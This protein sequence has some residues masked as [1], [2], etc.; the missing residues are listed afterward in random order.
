MTDAISVVVPGWRA[1]DANDE[2]ISGAKL[3]FYNA[4]TTTEKFVYS[5][6]DLTVSLGAVVTCDSEGYPTSDGNTRVIIYTGTAAYKVVCTTSDNTT[7]WSHDNVRGASVTPATDAAA[8]PETPVVSKTA[9]YVILTTDQGKLIKGVCTSGN[10][11]FTLPSAVEAGDGFRVGIQHAGTANICSISASQVI[12]RPGSGTSTSLV[13]RAYGQ[14]AWF[15]SDGATWTMSESVD[16]YVVGNNAVISVKDRTGTPPVSPTGGDFY[17][18]N[19]T[20]TGAWA[21][22]SL[23]ANTIVQADGSGSWIAMTPQLGWLAYIEDEQILSQYR[24]SGWVDLSNVTAPTS[25]NLEMAEFSYNV[26]ATISAATWTNIPHATTHF[27]GIT[28]ASLSAGTITLPTGKYL[29]MATIN[30]TIPQSI[31]ASI[32]TRLYSSSSSTSKIKSINSRA[33]TV[34]SNNQTAPSILIGYLSVTDAT[35]NFVHQWLSSS[36]SAVLGTTDG[37]GE[38]KYASITIFDLSSMQGPAGSAGSAGTDGVDA[39]HAYQWNTATSGDPGSGKIRGNNATIASITEIGISETNSDAGTVAVGTWDDSTSS[40]KGNIKV[41]KEGAGGSANYHEFA[42]TGA[43]TD[44]GSYWTFPVSYVGTS[45]T[46]GNGA[47]VAVLHVPKGDKGDTGSTGSAGSYA[48]EYTFDTGTTDA[49]PGAGKIRANNAMLSVATQLF[50]SETDRLSVSQAAAIQQF[51]DSTTTLRGYITL[52][53]VATP[54]NRVRFSISGSITDGGTYDKITV[55]YVSGVTTLTAVNVALIFERT[56]DKGP[57][58]AADITDSTIAGRALLT[59]A[60]ATAQRTALSLGSL[61]LLGSDAV[62]PGTGQMTV[63][64]GTTAQRSGSPGNGMFRYNSTLGVHEYYQKSAWQQLALAFIDI[65]AAY[66]IDA[67][68]GTNVASALQSAITAADTGGRGIYLAEGIYDLGSST[69]SI[70]AGMTVVCHPKAVLRRSAEPGT[71]ARMVTVASNVHWTGG[72]LKHSTGGSAVVALESAAMIVDQASSTVIQD[73]II[74]GR[75]Y[76]GLIFDRCT[77]SRCDGVQVWGSKNRAI[78]VYQ[79]CDDIRISNCYVNGY[80]FG[81]TTRYTDYCININ[82]ANTGGSNTITDLVIMNCTMEHPTNDGLTI[83]DLTNGV[84]VANCTVNNAGQNGFIVWKA[85]SNTPSGVALTNCVAQSCGNVGFFIID[86]FY[87]SLTGCHAR[88]CTAQGFAIAGS[89]YVALA[90]CQA[91]SNTSH[92]FYFY[93]NTGISN[94][95]TMVSCHAITNTGWGLLINAS[96]YGVGYAMNVIYAN[97]AGNI[98]D[99]GTSSFTSGNLTA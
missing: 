60:D 7:V 5:D 77:E 82:P 18:L 94:R 54:A 27:N 51:D 83:G 2:P 32:S 20:I 14:T 37:T 30:A 74:E 38:D 42:I 84:T 70:P 33:V 76:C 97:T 78:Y 22:S 65:Q 50:I 71:A 23:T 91:V 9:A 68:G 47:S 25:S 59:A 80:D 10:I 43:G 26:A 48:F 57:I 85:N 8:L 92:G 79:T 53:D 86:A 31:T 12:A 36:A 69:V 34:A 62:L 95:C 98:S 67:T 3:K 49:D 87:T 35:E 13:L 52:I 24:T 4:G 16:P 89:A 81:T 41:T 11:A 44:Q 17:L 56:G 64:S 45:G 61:A 1:T 21:A 72:T 6:Y 88:V 75:Y 28:G 29:V 55:A 46:I 58:A 63:P 93:S 99:G 96:Q 19:G 90:S 40:I 73:L 39:G 66:N 15:T